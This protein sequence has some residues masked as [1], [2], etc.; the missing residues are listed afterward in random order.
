MNVISI[1]D[2]LEF[3]FPQFSPPHLH[4]IVTDPPATHLTGRGIPWNLSIIFK[5]LSSSLSGE[6]S[7]TEMPLVRPRESTVYID[8]DGRTA[9]GQQEE[10][11]QTEFDEDASLPPEIL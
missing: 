9:E 7:T 8:M 1:T 3:K 11:P 5:R 10:K 2:N 6:A 4:N